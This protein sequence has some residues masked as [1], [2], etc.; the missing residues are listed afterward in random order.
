M[1][2]LKLKVRKKPPQQ[3]VLISDPNSDVDDMVSY[4]AAAAMAD[5]NRIK[6]A[7]V[8]ATGGDF[9]LRLRR[10]KL[11]KGC[12]IDLGHPFLKVS[13]GGDYSRNEAICDDYFAEEDN[14]QALE[15]KGDAVLRIPRQMLAE[16]FKKAEP[17][18]ITLV[19]NAQV[20]DAIIYLRE[21]GEKILKK[22]FRIIIMGGAFEERDGDGRIKPDLD[23]YNFKVCPKSAEELFR[24]AQDHKV[25]LVLMPRETVYQVPFSPEFY[26]RIKQSKNL[27]AQAIAKVSRHSLENLWNNIRNGVYSHFDIR[28]FAKVFMGMSYREALKEISGREDFAAIESKIRNFYLYDVFT[29]LAADDVS[30][31]QFFRL[32]KPNEDYSVFVAEIEDV[33]KVSREIEKLIFKKLNV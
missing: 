24:W 13:A 20:T 14:S 3:V 15:R 5:K 8:I 26:A 10:A 28:R 1:E 23:S 31:K 7:G 30:F 2:T 32:N 25:R 19:I 17:K 21:C 27:V 11:A 6:L 12:F 9:P 18:S 33:E 16:L 29:V 4:V 22:V